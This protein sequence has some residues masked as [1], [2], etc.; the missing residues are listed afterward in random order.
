MP[1]VLFTIESPSPTN[2]TNSILEYA[3]IPGDDAQ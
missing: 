2:L 1:V 3:L